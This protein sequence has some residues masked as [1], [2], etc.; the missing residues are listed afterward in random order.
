[1]QNYLSTA[2]NLLSNASNGDD[3]KA[4]LIAAYPDFGGRA[5]LDH[6]KRFLFPPRKEANV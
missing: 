6:Q 5:L 1:M 4:R 2:R 3:L